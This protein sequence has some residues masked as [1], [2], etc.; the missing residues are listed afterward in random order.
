M[1]SNISLEDVG[2]FVT[3]GI[4]DIPFIGKYLESY[5][6]TLKENLFLLQEMGITSDGFLAILMQELCWAYN[7]R[8]YGVIEDPNCEL[9]SKEITSALQRSVVNYSLGDSAKDMLKEFIRE[10]LGLEDGGSVDKLISAGL[11]DTFYR[12]MLDSITDI[13]EIT[14]MLSDTSCKFIMGY[15]EENNF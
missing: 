1:L 2:S 10:F 5:V 6:N 13:L 7:F 3:E 14:N 8:A 4:Y 12:Y 15:L 11:I 9:I